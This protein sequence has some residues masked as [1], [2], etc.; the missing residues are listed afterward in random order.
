M[1]KVD[2]ATIVKFN[3]ITHERVRWLSFLMGTF[4]SAYPK[5]TYKKF[6]KS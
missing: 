6:K 4:C 5:S 3:L 2:I 1:K